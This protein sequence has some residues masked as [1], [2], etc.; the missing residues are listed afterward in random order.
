MVWMVCSA[1]EGRNYI[2][3][4]PVESGMGRLWIGSD[5][6]GQKS[7]KWDKQKQEMQTSEATDALT[8]YIL[9]YKS[10]KQ[11]NI[12]HTTRNA[13]HSNTDKSCE[14]STLLLAV[15]STFIYLC[16]QKRQRRLGR[17]DSLVGGGTSCFSCSLCL[18]KG[19]L[20]SHCFSGD[21]ALARDSASQANCQGPVLATAV[22]QGR[23]QARLSG[24]GLSQVSSR[25]RRLFEFVSKEIYELNTQHVIHFILPSLLATLLVWFMCFGQLFSSV[26]GL[27]QNLFTNPAQWQSF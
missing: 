20:F 16:L 4:E 6:I 13:L 27:S 8:C 7:L 23:S 21:A 25:W 15:K 26:K 22:D 3:G 10:D 5:R 18:F 19:T 1:G 24:R 11:K 2:L 17:V 9:H 14:F 12:P